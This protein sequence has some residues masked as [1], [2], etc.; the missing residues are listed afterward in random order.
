MLSLGTM[1]NNGG[2]SYGNERNSGSGEGIE[3]GQDP[4]VTGGF[5]NSDYKK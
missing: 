3:Y 1:S 2:G 5:F 4:T